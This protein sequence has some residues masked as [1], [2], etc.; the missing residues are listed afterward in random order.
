M[1]YGEIA[2]GVKLDNATS[3]RRDDKGVRRKPDGD[4]NILSY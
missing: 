4:S 3:P 1:G 2:G